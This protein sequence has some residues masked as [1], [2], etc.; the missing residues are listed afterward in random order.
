MDLRRDWLL[1]ALLAAGQLSLWPG[2][3][4]WRGEPVDAGQ[5]AVGLLATSL[6]VIAL[7]WR[8]RAPLAALA[9]TAVTLTL[10]QLATPLDSLTVLTIADVI[11]L[12]SVAARRPTR[13]ALLAAAAY[14]VLSATL[15]THLLGLNAEYAGTLVLLVITNLSTIALGQ[16]RRRWRLAR[17]TA[18]DQLA[19]AEADRQQAAGAERHRLARELHDVSAHHLT[20][21]VVTVTAAQ[22]LAAKRPEL[23][24]AALDFAAGT[25]RETLAALH[26]LVAVMRHTDREG[27]PPLAERIDEL[28]TGFTRLGQP[29]TLELDLPPESVPAVRGA[30]AAYGIVREALTNTLRYAPGAPVRVR[31]TD[32]GDALEVTVSNPAPGNAASGNAAPGIGMLGSGRGLAGAAE[33]ATDLGGHLDA[34]PAPDGGWR[35]H[36][37]LPTD[38]DR[39][40]R[41]ARRPRLRLARPTDLAVLAACLGLPLLM[42]LVDEEQS[43]PPEGLD[44]TAGVLGALL[45]IGHALPLLWRR[46]APWTSLAVMLAMTVPWPLVVGYELLPEAAFI[47]LGTAVVAELAATYAVAVYS[48]RRALSWLAVPISAAVLGLVAAAAT[49][50]AGI[51]N[52][53]LGADESLPPIGILI[54]VV[55]IAAI[56]AIPGSVPLL[57]A[58]GAGFAIRVRND[59]VYGREHTA[60]AAT[61]ARVVA[62]VHAERGRIAA[63]LRDAVLRDTG[64][65]VAAA[66]E[67]RLD[68]VAEAARAALGGMRELLGGLREAPQPTAAAIDELC[69][70]HRAAGRQVELDR[71]ADP[72]VLPA[73]VELSAYR[74]VE[75][76]LGAGDL[77]PARVT[78]GY[79]ADG[80]RITVTGVPSAAAE[81]VAA[82][83]NAR[84]AGLGG[85]LTINPTGTMDVW[86]PAAHARS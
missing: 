85:R 58:W 10:G 82:G 74:L 15:S 22:R 83:L 26:Q 49:L 47:A 75:N 17:Q 41:S 12:F 34:G 24:E 4:L 64:R 1:P 59:R 37:V 69:E 23:T 73:A 32:L 28:T 70:R 27:G 39:S 79:S 76:A 19:R 50:V 13:T 33:R 66:E 14:T 81:P 18:A 40:E 38:P 21:I 44:A 31:I 72:P 48:A 54:G 6:V 30:D 2:V 52:G 5:L 86:L 35:V 45:L 84:A 11:A 3:P 53:D 8:R 29:I 56:L 20:A 78:L 57:L 71:P 25:G 77:A 60:L 55:F 43:G 65:V 63:G 68:A 16:G 51:G 36:A 62:E 61:T 67:R 9:G 80:L 42:L 46:R 7:A